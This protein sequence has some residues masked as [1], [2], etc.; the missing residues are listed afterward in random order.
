[1]SNSEEL[2]KTLA[3]LKTVK[4]SLETV[5]RWSRND[6]QKEAT[7]LQRREDIALIEKYVRDAR[8]AVQLVESEKNARIRQLQTDIEVLKGKIQTLKAIKTPL[9]ES[10]E[11]PDSLTF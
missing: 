10:E 9:P 5:E 3:L 6:K 8:F 2:K 7:L 1:M 4:T 11:Y